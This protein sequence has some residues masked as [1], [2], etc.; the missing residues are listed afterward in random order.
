KLND[1]SPSILVHHGIRLTQ[2]QERRHSTPE[3][4]PGQEFLG[5][6]GQGPGGG[7][8]TILPRKRSGKSPSSTLPQ[9]RSPVPRPEGPLPLRGPACIPARTQSGYA[10]DAPGPALPSSSA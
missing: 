7:E 5:A 2:V 6:R 4:P 10:R 1:I 8:S 3:A 9:T